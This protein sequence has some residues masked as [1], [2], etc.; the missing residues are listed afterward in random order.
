MPYTTSFR[1]EALNEVRKGTPHKE[2][3]RMYGI[4]PTTLTTWKKQDESTAKTI[5]K[6]T[7]LTP[8]IK[9][10]VVELRQQRW[11]ESHIAEKVGISKKSVVRILSS[12][13]ETDFYHVGGKISKSIDICPPE[14]NK[15]T[16]AT[17]T[18]AEAMEKLAETTANKA[19]VATRTI[20][21]AMEEHK[22]TTAKKESKPMDTT[23]GLSLCTIQ[24]KGAA[25]GILYDISKEN[26]AIGP[27]FKIS[28]SKLEGMIA[29][30][31]QLQRI[32]KALE[33]DPQ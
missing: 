14:L 19:T 13:P 15:T 6:R 2:I 7:V 20:A 8:E 3:C 30:L 33:L 9:A 5:K 26:V 23:T 11:S 22:E 17:Q 16:I 27:C 29:E 25:T 10:K 18:I 31:Q 28:K 21:E 24:I 32:V 4:S 12:H 1:A